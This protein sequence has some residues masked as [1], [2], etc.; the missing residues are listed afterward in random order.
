MAKKTEILILLETIQGGKGFRIKGLAVEGRG[1]RISG[2]R[3][4]E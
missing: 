2:F 4:Q 1:F 3:V